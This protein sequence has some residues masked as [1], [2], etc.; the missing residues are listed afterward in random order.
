MWDA[1]A[2]DAAHYAI[3]TAIRQAGAI[4]AGGVT[5]SGYRRDD[6]P[7]GPDN[8]LETQSL[9]LSPGRGSGSCDAR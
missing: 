9:G 2:F 4:P 5:A 7:G 1:V 6:A 3:G 8:Y